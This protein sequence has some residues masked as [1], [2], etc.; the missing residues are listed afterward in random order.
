MSETPKT[1][2]CGRVYP[3]S[4][5]RALPL[6]GYCA[7]GLD[8]DDTRGLELRNCLCGSTLAVEVTLPVTARA[9]AS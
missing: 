3:P 8:G 2:A 1:C 9:V 5:W 6:V 7:A 4:L